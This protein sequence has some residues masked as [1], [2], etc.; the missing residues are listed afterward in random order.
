MEE[1]TVT[2]NGLCHNVSFVGFM[3]HERLTKWLA[4]SFGAVVDGI[5]VRNKK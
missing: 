5:N 2:A 4:N 1:T 3:V